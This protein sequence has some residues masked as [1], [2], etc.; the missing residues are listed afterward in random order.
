LTFRS[1]G[2]GGGGKI[3]SSTSTLTERRY[4]AFPLSNSRPFAVKS[5]SSSIQNPK[6]KI[7][8]LIVPAPR[9]LAAFAPWR[10]RFLPKGIDA[11]RA[12]LQAIQNPKSNIQNPSSSA[13]LGGLR[14]LAVQISSQR[15]RRSQS[16]ATSH[17]K[18]KIQHSKS[19]FFRVP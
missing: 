1:L 17:S 8:N 4:N 15:H 9:P 12:T 5:S 3:F 18:S 10:F 11:H 19:L 6:F 2:E 13:S 16:D 14:A 7:Q